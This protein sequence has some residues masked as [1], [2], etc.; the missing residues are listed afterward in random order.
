MK[1]KIINTEVSLGSYQEQVNNIINLPKKKKSSYV[2]VCNVHML[3]EAHD[4]HQFGEFIN[5]A[6]I[7]TPDGMP[8]AKAFKILYGI[9]QP[10]VPGM[11]LMESLFADIQKNKMSVFLYGSTDSVLSSI[12][13]KAKKDFPLLNIIGK[14][15]PPFRN[16]TEDESREI[17]REI[18]LNSPDFVFVALGCPKQEKWMADNLNK[19]NSCMIGLGGAFPVY[20]GIVPRAPNWMQNY[21]LEWLYRLIKEPKRL[22]KRYFYTNIMFIYL[23]VV[24]TIKLK[25]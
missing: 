8:V 6:D 16:I 24:Q 5:N 13:T 14:L 17:N 20:A 9:S 23:L 12:S 15:S 22:W 21:G 3:I 7:V 4:S 11:D 25:K 1:K 10:R 19:I 2:C 18:N